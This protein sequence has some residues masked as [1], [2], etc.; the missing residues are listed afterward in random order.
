MAGIFARL[1]SL[2]FGARDADQT[3][4][5]LPRPPLKPVPSLSYPS[6][7]KPTASQPDQR[8]WLVFFIPGNPGLVSYYTPFL[9]SLRE[10]LDETEARTAAG[11]CASLVFHIY[12]Q[13]L[14]GFNDA[15]H[16]PFG[17]ALHRSVTEPG[18]GDA[19]PISAPFTIQQQID[20]L[21]SCLAALKVQQ[22]GPR[23]G[24]PFDE[25]VL[26][27]HSL[28]TF[29][30]LD[31][32]HRRMLA[33]SP[34]LHEQQIPSSPPRPSLRAG[35][36]LFP[37]I[38]HLARSPSGRWMSMLGTIRLLDAYAHHV[39]KWGLNLVPRVMLDIVLRRALRLPVAAAD[40]TSLLL[41]S[42]DGLWQVIEMGKEE[43]REIRGADE[44]WEERVWEAPAAGV[45]R[46]FLFY[47]KSDG[48]VADDLR[49]DF[50][51][52]REEHAARE[53]RARTRIVIDE[54]GLPHNFSLGEC[55]T[56]APLAWTGSLGSLPGLSS[57]ARQRSR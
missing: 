50:I 23:K 39:A 9:I 25:V 7:A 20:Q 29:I 37:A 35:I 56:Q 16:V 40:T 52:R 57:L 19:P 44:R 17:T 8:H 53:P 22:D 27:G 13:D 38:E 47:G 2:A 36:L 12:A 34:Q 4:A 33:S 15:D 6:S 1:K 42:R 10:L 18:D 45:E 54:D 14:L 55:I 51:R 49:A 28:G 30:A 11:T 32:F 21:D 26:I 5:D 41:G 3:D 24:T 48:W 43:M 46:F 31:I